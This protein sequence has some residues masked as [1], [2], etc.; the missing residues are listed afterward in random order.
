ML[1]A[2]VVGGRVGCLFFLTRA[3]CACINMPLRLGVDAAWIAV[4]T[5]TQ[6]LF[7]LG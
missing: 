7:E 6:C 5:F 3:Q 2:V 1:Q 4:S